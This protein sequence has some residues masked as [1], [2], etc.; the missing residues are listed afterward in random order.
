MDTSSKIS[1]RRRT[2]ELVGVAI[3]V[4][5]VASMMWLKGVPD[6]LHGS[7][8]WPLPGHSAVVPFAI[9]YLL[10]CGLYYAVRFVV[11]L[12]MSAFVVVG[13]VNGGVV[14]TFYGATS[15]SLSGGRLLGMA[16]SGTL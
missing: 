13:L 3:C 12:R 10:S 14:A 16:I 5:L 7:S 8:Y 11:G 15:S 9:G 4:P 1:P 2:F 6:P